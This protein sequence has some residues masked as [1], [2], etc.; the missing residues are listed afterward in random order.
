MAY[1]LV[2]NKHCRFKIIFRKRVY[3][4]IVFFAYNIPE[5]L[6]LLAQVPGQVF[7][8]DGRADLFYDPV[9]KSA[10]FVFLLSAESTVDSIPELHIQ[11]VEPAF[12]LQI[13]KNGFN[14]LYISF[15]FGFAF[16]FIFEL[17]LKQRKP[18]IIDGF[19]PCDLGGNRI[20]CPCVGNS[21]TNDPV[22]IINDDGFGGG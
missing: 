5:E 1:A 22:I 17:H 7:I 18:C 21:P 13:L 2:V 11:A 9:D 15:V 19:E 10:D 12:E 20:I 16:D 14:I 4:F 3:I 8:E 6:I